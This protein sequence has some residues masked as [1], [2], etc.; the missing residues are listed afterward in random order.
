MSTSDR[1]RDLTAAAVVLGIVV[2]VTWPLPVAMVRGE[3]VGHPTGDLADHVQGAWWFAGELLGGRWPDTTTVTH[4]P[5]SL[6]LWFVDP[7]GALLAA[8]LWAAG[9]AVAW[10]MALIGQVLLTAV[11][12]FLAGRDLSGRRAGGLATAA[13]V[14]GSPYLLGLLHSGL[15]EGVGLA[16][17]VGAAWALLRATGRDPRGRPAPPWMPVVAGACIAASGLQSAYYGAFSGLLA[18]SCLPGDGW[19]ARVLPVVQSLAVGAVLSLP[20]LWLLT[21]SL[22]AA[23]SAVSA[24]NAPGWVQGALP[25]TDALMFGMPGAYYFPDTPALGNPGILHVVYLGWAAAALAVLGMRR[26]P[27]GI[28]ARA[29]LVPLVVMGLLALGPVLAVG[30]RVVG[31]GGLPVPLPLALLYVPG[32]PFRLV[33]HPYRLV[34]ALLPL[35]GI[36]AAL[37]TRALPRAA[38]WS[39]PA[40]ILA[41]ALLVSPA[42]WPLATA[43]ATAP[44]LYAALPPGPVLDWPP[45]AT[46][47]N[48]SYQLQQPDHGRAVPYGVNVF[49]L[50]ALRGDP[51]VEDLLRALDDIGGRARN[52]DVPGAPLP[53][54][55]RRP[56]TTG[57]EGLGF[58]AV[59]LHGDALDEAERARAEAVLERHLGQSSAEEGSLEAWVVPPR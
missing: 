51:L 3:V 30:R 57:L 40:V 43:T 35:L 13:V 32:S 41:E 27:A 14:A 58:R 26:P 2:A 10:N 55:P 36:A 16:P 21:D 19:K 11:A 49:V 38:R 5:A 56:G 37:G 12:A 34:A 7:V 29:L 45:D 31:V 6:R 48:R 53:P 46:R 4:F 39:V 9:A 52:R 59:V 54:V 8:P 42:Q 28:Q 33:H 20:V 50:D 15:S 44:D 24:A 47:A 18:L 22:G 17:L 1:R 23:D 25:A